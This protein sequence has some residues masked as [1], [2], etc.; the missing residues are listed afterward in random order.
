LNGTFSVRS[1]ALCT[2]ISISSPP[3]RYW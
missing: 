3:G 2:H 1:L